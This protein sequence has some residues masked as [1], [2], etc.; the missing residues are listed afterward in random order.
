MPG[1]R[2][3]YCARCWLCGCGA[4]LWLASAQACSGHGDAITQVASAPRQPTGAAASGS[5]TAAPTA[6]TSVSSHALDA[7]LPADAPALG[8]RLAPAAGS[9]GIA[10]AGVGGNS[11]SS[12]PAASSGNLPTPAGVGSSPAPA[13]ASA[14]T[15]AANSGGRA[16]PAPSTPA[17]KEI[18]GAD[19][20]LP[21]GVEKYL[22]VR[23]T[24][25]EDV[26]MNT[27]HTALSA[28]T[29]HMA[30][31][32][33]PRAVKP[34]GTI[35]CNLFEVGER[36]IVGGGPGTQDL[37]LPAGVGVKFARGNQLLLQL[38][39]YNVT[40]RALPGRSAVQAALIDRAQVQVEAEGL[41]AQLVLLD[42]PP[43]RTV[44]SGV[45]TFDRA[46][47]LAAITP[48]MHKAGRRVKAVLHSAKHGEMVLREGDFD[49]MEQRHYLF[50]PVEVAAGDYLTYEC[51]F[52]NTEQRTLHFGEST[53]DEM[54]LMGVVRYPA[55]GSGVCLF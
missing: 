2:R 22:C 41:A 19:W 16:A 9:S 12:T 6:A 52:E 50:G 10:A 26:Y 42:I 23:T 51:T 34:D 35:E 47:S 21:P 29:H 55:G 18:L 14:G 45:C 49:F 39:L 25:T 31:M 46:Q 36:L 11:G 20:E 5:A 38:H 3:R 37:V 54:C 24:A 1:R 53:N 48:H 43:G 32:V 27:L 28:G 30:L 44:V 4:M 33:D 17:F 40:D 7:P 15:G 13:A 8:S